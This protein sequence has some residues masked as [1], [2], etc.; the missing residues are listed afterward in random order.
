[1]N[2][3][4]TILTYLLFLHEEADHTIMDYGHDGFEC[5]PRMIA[6]ENEHDTAY[7]RLDSA[8]REAWAAMFP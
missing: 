1:M 8:G 2:D 5:E 3:T 7:A 6:L 4:T